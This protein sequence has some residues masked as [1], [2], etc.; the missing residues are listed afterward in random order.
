MIGTL[1]RGGAETVALDICGEVPS[2]TAHQIFVT[3]GGREGRLAPDFRAAGATV[4]QCPLYPLI[5]FGPRLWMTFRRLRPDVVVSHV[6]LS[7]GFI[8]TVARLAGIT[9]RVARFHSEDDGRAGTIG[10][11]LQRY[12]MRKALWL[13]ATDVVGVTQSALVY[14]LG[15]PVP[16]SDRRYRVLYN[17]VN[18]SRLDDADRAT[19]R[20]A[21]ELPLDATVLVHIARSAPEK[22]R[23]FL[24]DVFRAARARRPK[25]R[26]LV[27]GAG[28]TGDLAEF[29]DD[30]SVLF[31]GERD[32]IGLILAASDV[33][34]LP[35]LREGLPGVVLE[36]LSCGVL[37][38]ATNLPGL[39]EVRPALRG[40]ML[41]ELA[42]GP[43]QWAERA[44]EQADT[45]VERRQKTRRRF[46]S[47]PFLLEKVVAH[48]VELFR[49]RPV[50]TRVTWPVWPAVALTVLL[51][52]P[53]LTTAQTFARQ[54]VAICAV[55]VAGIAML[56][57]RS[58]Y[59]IY[60][61]SVFYLFLLG[62]F[63]GGLLF[64]VALRG[65]DSLNVLQRIWLNAGYT[66]AAAR[67]ALLGILAFSLAAAAA[68]SPGRAKGALDPP[69]PRSSP[70]FGSI[71]LAVQLLGLAVALIVVRRAGGFD[72]ITGGYVAFLGRVDGHLIGYGILFLSIGAAL[73]VA[74][75]G[76]WRISAWLLFILVALVGI[77]LGTRSIVMF[78][79]AA[80]LA[81]E[82]RQGRRMR[83]IVAGGF[84]L[85]VLVLSAVVFTSRQRGL[86][87]LLSASW[88][89][90]PLNTVAEM[91]SSLRPATVV[92]GWHAR[93]EAFRYGATLIAVPLRV[94]ERWTGWH[95]GPPTLDDRLL[96]EEMMKRVGPIGGSPIAEGYHNFGTLGVVALLGIFG[97][98]TGRLDARYSTPFTDA[99][100]GVV[101]I[102]LLTEIRNGAAVLLPQIA[103][104]L[105]AVALAAWI[106]TRRAGGE[107]R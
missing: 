84:V 60:S 88:A 65:D 16:V 2:E 38:I 36:A 105:A 40:L 7:S 62:L 82:A 5:T 8:L 89:V 73:G 83:P 100:T 6:D 102:P 56:A 32:D 79:L 50:A 81:L 68:M 47:S 66:P 67:L 103:I 35:S 93:G 26:L 78:P 51:A 31:A 90:S 55:W 58:R 104:G 11:R 48:W 24:G 4:E 46:R 72:A 42:A 21:L 61:A 13:F 106:A 22:N 28:G 54:A 77:P 87:G 39:R 45:S 94:V 30:P 27:V 12:V 53:G 96:Q 10:R 18:L 9:G 63:H 57:R 86:S 19:A 69:R 85:A 98:I 52:L 33:L 80:M 1:D 75:G 59:G 34:L 49:R 101:L 71:G 17:G 3:L 23:R 92:V 43:Q 64:S 37:V 41:L 95:G 107:S 29:A 99:T 15:G 91:G 20:R 44:L 76:R 97:V 70:A 14:A 74:A 25:T